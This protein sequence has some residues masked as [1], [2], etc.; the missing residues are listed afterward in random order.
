MAGCVFN[1]SEI[2]KKKRWNFGSKSSN[3]NC[4]CIYYYDGY[5]TPV[6]LKVHLC[7]RCHLIEDVCHG[8]GGQVL[9]VLSVL[10]EALE[11]LHT[12]QHHLRLLKKQKTVLRDH[13]THIYELCSLAAR[14]E[15]CCNPGGREQRT[16]PMQRLIK[17]FDVE[18]S[19][20]L[21]APLTATRTLYY[22][23]CNMHELIG[24]KALISPS[25]MLISRNINNVWKIAS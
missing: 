21:L 16:L 13:K 9:Q 3:L 4:T 20:L 19:H 25:K 7:S 10:A 18:P 11:E 2:K 6:R 14:G 17:A 24:N 15:M 12:S 8:L 23:P 1:V 22:C 5:M